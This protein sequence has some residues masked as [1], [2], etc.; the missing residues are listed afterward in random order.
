MT[1]HI[2]DASKPCVPGRSWNNGYLDYNQDDARNR[3]REW[4]KQAKYCTLFDFPTKGI[5]QVRCGRSWLPCG[6]GGREGPVLTS[7]G[8]QVLVSRLEY[9]WGRPA[10]GQAA[11]RKDSQ[12]EGAKLKCICSFPS[13]SYPH[14]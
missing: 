2:T 13:S 14:P 5:V 7:V 1:A 4:A 3:L 10:C 12:E 9:L 6:Q 8:V 11:A